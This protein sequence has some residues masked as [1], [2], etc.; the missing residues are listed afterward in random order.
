MSE[1]ALPNSNWSLAGARPRPSRERLWWWSLELGP[2][3]LGPAGAGL[4][5]FRQASNLFLPQS[6]QTKQVCCYRE[7]AAMAK[8]GEIAWVLAPQPCIAAVMHF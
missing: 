7:M 5:H 2:R 6:T 8:R 4:S 3:A 1:L